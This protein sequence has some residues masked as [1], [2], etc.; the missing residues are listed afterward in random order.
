MAVDPVEN[1][2]T[3]QIRMRLWHEGDLIKEEIHTQRLDD[4]SKN[5]LVLMLERAGFS[6]VQVFGDFSDEPATAD[7]HELIFICRK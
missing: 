4:Y 1:V 2:A 3:R 7:H 5:E 6:D